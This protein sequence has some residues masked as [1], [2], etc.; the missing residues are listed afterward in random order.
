MVH[1]TILIYIKWNNLLPNTN[2]TRLSELQQW[3]VPN[4]LTHKRKGYPSLWL[5]HQINQQQT[6]LTLKHHQHLSFRQH[7]NYVTPALIWIL[8]TSE[9]WAI[10][11]YNTPPLTDMG[12]QQP[13]SLAL[14]HN[15]KTRIIGCQD[16]VN[17][18]HF[19]T[20]NQKLLQQHHSHLY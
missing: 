16:P 14:T 3:S 20:S 6:A 15:H 18:P 10:L 1:R 2:H 19:R 4:I 7:R 17:I 12:Y 11:L 8:S 13:I 5:P 9:Y